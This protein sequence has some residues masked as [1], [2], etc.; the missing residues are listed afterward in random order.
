MIIRM[1]RNQNTIGVWY[2]I[3]A[4]T[5]WGVLP[6][7]WKA[8]D[9]IPAGEI[10]AHRIL[11]SFVLVA[12]LMG[13]Y[14]RLNELKKIFADKKSVVSV[15][16]GSVLIS[17]NW[18][19]YIW[20]VNN[21]HV[22]ETSLGYYINPLIS[23][24]LGVLVLKE[25]L[26]SRQIISLALAA[27]GVAITTVHYG[28]IPWVALLLALSFGLYGLVKKKA[29]LDSLA[30]LALETMFVAPVSVIYLLTRYSAGSGSPG[31]TTVTVMLMLVFSG[32]VTSLPLYWFAQGTRSVPLSTIGF[33]QYLA[34][35][36]SLTLGIFVFKEPFS[37]IDTISFGFI[38]TALLFYSLSRLEFAEKLGRL[39]QNGIMKTGVKAGK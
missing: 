34:P 2:A 22:V 26:D 3:A 29:G 21:N 18:F 14:G 1:R 16:A 9:K 36:I 20:A 7:Y 38:W 10:L 6:L 35:T 19:F 30:S 28:K 13:A 5:T 31:T 33:I 23:I 4:F 25:R 27:I 17:S 12:C 32:V 37:M 8:L 39:V 15:A 11:W 24:L